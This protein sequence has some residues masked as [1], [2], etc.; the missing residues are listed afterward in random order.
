MKRQRRSKYDLHDYG[1][2]TVKRREF[3]KRMGLLAGSLLVAGCKSPAPTA[4]AGPTA[5]VQPPTSTPDAK[6][7]AAVAIGQAKT[8]DRAE[9]RKQVEAMFDQLGG[10]AD[11]I[12]TGDKVVI[13]VNLTCGNQCNVAEGDS[14]TESFMTHPAVVRAAAE[15]IRDA[16]A[17]KIYI[18]EALY[19]L[20]SFEAN[21][22]AAIA[23]DMGLELVNLNDP[24]PYADFVKAPVKGGG[25]IFQDFTLHPILQETDKFVSIAKM[26]C[27]YSTGVTLS[28][29]NLVGITPVSL[30]R[31]DPAHFWRSALHGD[32]SETPTRLPKIILDLVRTRPIHLAV[33]DGVK[34]GEGGEVP[35]GSFKAVAPGLLVAGKNPTATDTVSTALMG[36]DPT[37]E[38]PN[39]PFLHSLN[40]L[41]LANELGVGTNHLDEIR[42]LGA[43][44]EDVRFRFNPSTAM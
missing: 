34:T 1:A 13:K 42:V 8:Y 44:I 12:H 16:G 33:I 43:K 30:Y 36:F 17:G 20:E 18:A 2:G 25:S 11:V 37:A 14:T 21:G 40:H 24:A 5:P 9:I 6:I 23:K 15:L 35:R 32:E 19:D 3:I 26:K 4:T 31:S 7:K 10:L 27:H 38:T 41:K 39:A 28:M 29:K 22:Y